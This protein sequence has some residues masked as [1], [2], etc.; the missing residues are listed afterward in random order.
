MVD[1]QA[2][3][4]VNLRGYKTYAWMGS[5]QIIYDPDGRWEPR[6]IDM[7]AEIRHL[8]NR[9]LRKRGATEVNSDPDMVV[10]YAAGIDMAALELKDNPETKLPMLKNVPKGA[11]VVLF[12]DSE[13]AIPIWAGLA[14]AEIQ[15]DPPTDIV[16]KR[17]D[18]A[19][20]KMFKKLFR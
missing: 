16:R 5:A 10:A 2:N 15:E 8:I 13:T 17:L 20:N 7:D 11:L 18:Y 4:K 14:E 12:I 6:K 3:P 1:A 9:E 19:V